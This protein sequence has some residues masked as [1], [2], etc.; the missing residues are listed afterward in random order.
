MSLLMTSHVPCMLAEVDGATMNRTILEQRT[1]DS[2][3]WAL[4]S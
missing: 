2:H 3:M 4:L 1:R